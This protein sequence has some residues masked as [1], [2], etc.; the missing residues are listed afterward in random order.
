MQNS[1]EKH[2]IVDV[3]TLKVIKKILKKSIQKIN[4]P[5]NRPSSTK[6]HAITKQTKKERE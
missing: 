1:R 4:V 3:E 6:N 5:E 2:V